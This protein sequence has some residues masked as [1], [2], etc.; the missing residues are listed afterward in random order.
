MQDLRT[1]PPNVPIRKSVWPTRRSP[2]W[3][4][5]AIAAFLAVAV[6][7]GLV[8]RPSAGERASDLRG[9]IGQL[10]SDVQSCS[11]GVGESLYVL[12]RIDSG[13]SSDV[14]GALNVATTASAN[15][16][17]A[18]NMSLDDLDQNVQVPSS[19]DGYRL[20]AGVNDLITWTAPDAINVCADVAKA[21]RD[22]GKPSEAA[23][24]AA[25]KLAQGKLD[26]QRA[27]V[28]ADFAPAI[29]AIAPHARLFVLQG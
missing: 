16:S 12:R 10:R 7:V 20:Q 2:W 3:V 11:G 4:F 17:P 23:A 13:K 6:A 1:G 22:R 9:L 29:K 21:L 24:L 8:H 5:A 14:P 26:A 19:L 15:C 25:L 27:V 28:Y 18:N